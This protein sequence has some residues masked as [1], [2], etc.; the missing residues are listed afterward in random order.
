DGEPRTLFRDQHFLTVGGVAFSPD[1]RLLALGN[2]DGRVQLWDPA[3]GQEVRQWQAHLHNVTL[4]FA[5]DG[6]TLVTGSPLDS[7]LRFWDPATGQERT[8]SVGHQGFVAWVAFS[9]DGRTLLTGARDRT[10]RRWDV[11]SG[12]DTVLFSW[13]AVNSPAF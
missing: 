11:A 8:T 3:T 7:A 12:T 10:V 13:P 5:P 4:T 6:K 2:G 1:G 9:P